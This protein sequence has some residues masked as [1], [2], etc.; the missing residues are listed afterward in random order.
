[1]PLPDGRCD[2]KV[3]N[4]EGGPIMGRGRPPAVACGSSQ[5]DFV[6]RSHPPSEALPS[7]KQGGS[8]LQPHPRGAPLCSLGAQDPG[9]AGVLHGRAEPADP[10][11]HR[12]WGPAEKEPPTHPP[13]LV[14]EGRLQPEAVRTFATASLLGRITTLLLYE[15]KT[16]LNFTFLLLQML[17]DQTPSIPSPELSQLSVAKPRC[18]RLPP[19]IRL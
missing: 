18:I 12:A 11:S 17:H 8:Q 9:W 14:E 4:T 7:S 6:G 16:V 13:H 2:G 10:V 15:Y 5:E 3:S 1:M 19:S